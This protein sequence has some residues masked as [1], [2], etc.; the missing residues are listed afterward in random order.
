MLE[1]LLQSLKYMWDIIICFSPLI[2]LPCLP[3]I[4]FIKFLDRNFAGEGFGL[5][6]LPFFITSKIIN[7]IY[8]R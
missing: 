2:A 4:F 3:N 8:K 6:G 1:I 7:N 5:F